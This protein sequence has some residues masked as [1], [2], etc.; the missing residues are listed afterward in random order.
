MDNTTDVKLRSKPELELKAVELFPFPKTSCAW[1]RKKILYQR[2]KWVE[3]QL[4]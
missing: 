1:M 2:E 4:R 3:A